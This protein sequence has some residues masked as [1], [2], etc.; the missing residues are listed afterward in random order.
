MIS[1]R[2]KNVFEQLISA[3]MLKWAWICIS[4]SILFIGSSLLLGEDG[5]L[6]PHALETIGVAL[7]P[8]GTFMFIYELDTR[9]GYQRLVRDEFSAAL[10]ALAQKCGQCEDAGLLALHCER[11]NDFMLKSIKAAGKGN[12]IMILGTA[13]AHFADDDSVNEELMKARQRGMNIRILVLDPS[14]KSA[15]VHE[16]LE[17]R[18]KGYVK[19]RLDATTD[20]FLENLDMSVTGEYGS[21]DIHKYDSLP[22]CFIF[23]DDKFVYVG[24]YLNDCKG[25]A[26]PHFL[27][28]REGNMAKQFIKHYECLWKDSSPL[29]SANPGRAPKIR[30]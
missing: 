5:N 30:R 6:W 8:I 3:R 11:D 7:L 21:L 19:K 9:T 15:D 25:A 28:K 18:A 4:F 14:C 12:T 27:F 29:E 13:A 20:R 16:K 23:A 10:S 1:R 24:L 22:K 17:K 26:S 2:K